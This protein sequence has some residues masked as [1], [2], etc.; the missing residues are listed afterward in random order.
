[1][2][3]IEDIVGFTFAEIAF[4]LL[5]IIFANYFLLEDTSSKKMV[6]LQNYLR[7]SNDQ[8]LILKSELDELKKKE[9]LRSRQK[10]SCIER[11][12]ARSSGGIGYLFTVTILGENKYEINGEELTYEQILEKYKEDIET[13]DKIGCVHSIK[14]VSKVNSWEI[15]VKSYKKLM[16]KFYTTII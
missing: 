3:D 4:V 6:E 5:Y 2:K 1:M 16:Q 11:K 7:R 9:K 14:V 12:I 10:P 15:Y 8:I 13:A